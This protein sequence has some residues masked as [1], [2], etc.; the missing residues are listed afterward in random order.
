MSSGSR[1]KGWFWLQLAPSGPLYTETTIRHLERRLH[2]ER[3][4]LRAAGVAQRL[5][6]R[7]L[8]QPRAQV[9]AR[10][11]LLL[12]RNRDLR[13]SNWVSVLVNSA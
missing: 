7:R 9:P 13:Q 3:L 10:G 5:A 1:T 2:H 4:A 6:D 12:R 8:R 11:H